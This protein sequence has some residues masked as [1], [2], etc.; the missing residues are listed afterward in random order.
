MIKVPI[1]Q[2]PIIIPE[3]QGKIAIKKTRSRRLLHNS[4]AEKTFNSARAF[5]TA[6]DPRIAS[7]GGINLKINCSE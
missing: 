1:T 3:Q 5:A 4:F 2:V 7:R 6:N